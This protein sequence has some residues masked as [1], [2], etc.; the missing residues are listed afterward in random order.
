MNTI[1]KDEIM[2][3]TLG[4]VLFLL[5]GYIFYNFFRKKTR[6]GLPPFTVPSDI[7]T[8]AT[9]PAQIA[10]GVAGTVEGAVADVEGA[11][12]LIETAATSAI[13]QSVDVQMTIWD[14]LKQ[15]AMFSKTQATQLA[16]GAAT[17]AKQTAIQAENRAGQVAMNVKNEAKTIYREGVTY[18]KLSKTLKF[19]YKTLKKL[20]PVFKWVWI[21]V[22]L[23][24]TIGVWTV[25]TIEVLIYRLFHIKDCF[26]W[27]FLEIV[28]FI[29][30]VPIEFFVWLFRMK[31]VEESFWK[32]VED[33]DCFF[34]SVTGFHI[35]H[36]SDTVLKKCYSKR[37]PPFPYSAIKFEG[38]GEF[39]EA[40]FV[41]FIAEWFLPPSPAEVGQAVQS[42]TQLMKENPDAINVAANVVKD[43]I[44][45]L[46]KISPPNP[47]E[48][49]NALG[50]LFSI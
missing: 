35:F 49:K 34:N 13:T 5:L 12:G 20:W 17:M 8:L 19:I 14:Y 32:L 18:A 47:N 44:S 3:L 4:I 40:E 1:L 7:L 43:E 11:M 30:Y 9:L 41:K 46:F 26:L 31:F 50:N 29:I 36:Y 22:K 15:M 21:C 45:D 27:Y 39:T 38:E 24:N 28:G 16:A 23:M 37:I 6:E 2:I 25:R 10:T 42:A 33:I 48:M